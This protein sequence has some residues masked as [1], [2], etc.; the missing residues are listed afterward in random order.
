VDPAKVQLT[1]LPLADSNLAEVGQETVSLSRQ[2]DGQ[3]IQAAAGP[4]L[5]VWHINYPATGQE[6]AVVLRTRAAFAGPG[7]GGPMLDANGRVLG[8]VG[9]VTNYL[10]TVHTSERHNKQTSG[11][12]MA[13]Y[14]VTSLMSWFSKYYYSTQATGWLGCGVQLVDKPNELR[15][16]GLPRAG[17]LVS[18]AEHDTPAATAG[19]RGGSKV[20]V[21]KNSQWITGGD[22]ILSI[23]GKPFDP[24]LVS[25][26]KPGDIVRLKVLKGPNYLAIRTVT[27]RLDTY[28]YTPRRPDV[29]RRRE[30]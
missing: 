30:T 20:V 9:P 25:K 2:A 15:A 28:P 10:D 18:I 17:Y 19:I 3:D 12:A 8:I 21:Y 13:S 29:A 11:S 6:L 1:P 14:G 7:R 26:H 24:K 22:L 5:A 4:L 23:D 27:V 16:L